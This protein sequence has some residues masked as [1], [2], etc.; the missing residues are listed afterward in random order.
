MGVALSAQAATVDLITN[1]DFETGDFTGWSVSGTF[2]GTYTINDGTLNPPGPA[3]VL[4]PITGSYDAIGHQTGGSVAL[5]QQTISVPYGIYSTSLTWND[6]IRNYAASFIDPGQEYR[7][8]ILDMANT[9]LQEVYSTNTGDTLLQIGPNSRSA[10]LTGLLQMYEGQMVVLSIETQAQSF[11]HT[12][13]VDDVHLLAGS[14]PM[15][16]GECKK[17]GWET[18]VN[19]NSG[20]QIF[21]NQGDCVSFVAS[22]G[23]N[24]PE[25]FEYE[26]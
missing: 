17:G 21:K 2:S 9:V 5:L 10:D 3:G 23:K 18:F 1:G 16:K 22:Q 13:T 6:R 19:V 25:N 11:F 7:V 12:V 15:D 8:L 26:E 4:P 24:P 14:L 20:T